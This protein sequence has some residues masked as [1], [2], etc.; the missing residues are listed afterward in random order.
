MTATIHSGTNGLGQPTDERGQVLNESE[1]G[2]ILALPENEIDVLAF[3]DRLLAELK[4]VRD[5]RAQNEATQK[6]RQREMELR[7]EDLDRPLAVTGARL[8]SYLKQMA[9][10]II[11]PGKKSRDLAWGSLKFIAQPARLEVV[12]EE[13]VA[14][15]VRAT[16]TQGETALVLEKVTTEKL[17]KKALDKVAESYKAVPDGCVE[18]PE[19]QKFYAEPSADAPVL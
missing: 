17:R 3:A 11:R 15:W 6:V 2:E 18:V 19:S 5:E 16:C 7:Y 14:A 13:K 9:P 10:Q 8:V 12:D 4:A 1:E